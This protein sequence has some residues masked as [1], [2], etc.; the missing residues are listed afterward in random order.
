M[1]Y[2]TKHFNNHACVKIFLRV[3]CLIQRKKK[4]DGPGEKINL[5]GTAKLQ[6]GIGNLQLRSLKSYAYSK[7]HNT[8]STFS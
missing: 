5:V 4:L 3:S 6:V 2:Y 7:T 8:Y 1:L